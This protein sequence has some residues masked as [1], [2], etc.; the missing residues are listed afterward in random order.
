MILYRL[1]G[2]SSLHSAVGMRQIDPVVT[3][4]LVEAQRAAKRFVRDCE[5]QGAEYDLRLQ[6]LTIHKPS[7]ALVIRVL[8]EDHP[9]GLIEKAETIERWTSTS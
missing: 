4:S 3:S 6:H 7:Q 1:C 8:S 2:R 5:K 9:A